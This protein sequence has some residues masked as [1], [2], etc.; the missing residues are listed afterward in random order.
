MYEHDFEYLCETASE[1]MSKKDIIS[2]LVIFSSLKSVLRY[3]K[4]IVITLEDED[5][6]VIKTN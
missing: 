5:K 2:N 1:I 6:V 4:M 3:A